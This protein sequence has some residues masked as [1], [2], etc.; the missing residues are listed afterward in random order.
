[1]NGWR[2]ILTL[3]LLPAY[4]LIGSAVSYLKS[5]YKK[6]MIFSLWT[7]ISIA[8][9]AVCFSLTTAINNDNEFHESLNI[10]QIIIIGD[11][12]LY[13]LFL[14]SFFITSRE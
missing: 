5:K 12:I 6:W 7:A 14:L 9:W 8:V 13:I 10:W 2:I 11:L 4:L 3:L 1:M